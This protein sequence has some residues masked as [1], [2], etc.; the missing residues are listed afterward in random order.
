MLNPL[1][2]APRGDQDAF[3]LGSGSV[4]LLAEAIGQYAPAVR[5]F[6][7]HKIGLLV[8]EVDGIYYGCR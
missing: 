5:V 1:L 7:R 3:G 4:P 8:F 6:R 2:P